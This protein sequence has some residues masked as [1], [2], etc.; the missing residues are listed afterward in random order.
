MRCLEGG[1]VAEVTMYLALVMSGEKALMLAPMV[2]MLKN[3]EL[4]YWM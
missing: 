2:W 1:L 4:E 3:L